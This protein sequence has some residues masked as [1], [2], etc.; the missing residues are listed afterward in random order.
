MGVVNIL[1]PTSKTI[2]IPRA[3]FIKCHV[4]IPLNKMVLLRESIDILWKPPSLYY[5]LP[6][7]LINSGFMLVLLPSI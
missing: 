7:S 6:I 5:K 4:P 1:A 3:L 2:F